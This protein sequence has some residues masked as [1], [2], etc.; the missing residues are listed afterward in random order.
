MMESLLATCKGVLNIQH[1]NINNIVLLLS[2]L[3]YL[4]KQI[5]DAAVKLL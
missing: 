1:V 4:P 5:I 2:L 3:N